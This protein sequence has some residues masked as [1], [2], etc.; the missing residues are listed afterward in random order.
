MTVDQRDL[1]DRAPCPRPSTAISSYYSHITQN[2]VFRKAPEPEPIL[3]IIA[4]KERLIYASSGIQRERIATVGVAEWA[5]VHAT[6]VTVEASRVRWL[7]IRRLPTLP[8][9][10]ARGGGMTGGA[11]ADIRRKITPPSPS[12][13][14]PQK[15]RQT[16]SP[17]S[18][19]VL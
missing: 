17:A 8:T 15:P 13:M 18:L 4:L 10:S 11:D 6:G 1:H 12:E 5:E 16:S 19:L 2:G 14:P 7:V 3:E 9:F